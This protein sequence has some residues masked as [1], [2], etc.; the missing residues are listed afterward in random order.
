MVNNLDL[1]K[2]QASRL[3]EHALLSHAH[4]ELEPRI[5][6]EGMPLD[7]RFAGREGNMLVFELQLQPGG[8]APL[9]IIGAFCEV[10]TMLDGEAFLFSTCILDVVENSAPPRIMVAVPTLI[11]VANRRRFERTNA[12][13]ASEV[14][15]VV[16]GQPIESVGLLSNIGADGLGCAVPAADFDDMLLLGDSVRARFEVAGFD[17]E[18]ELDAVVCSKTLNRDRSQLTLG[19]EFKVADGDAAGAENL[20][21]LRRVLVE[22]MSDANRSEDGR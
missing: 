8:S 14:R 13:V 7:V 18:F 20:A 10:R 2:R 21:N 4:A 12:T 15:L 1:T 22:L 17:Q 11:Q 5:G 19:L 16:D 3:L 9:G 6:E